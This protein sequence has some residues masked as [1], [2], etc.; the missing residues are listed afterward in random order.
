MGCGVWAM[1][2]VGMLAFHLNVHIQSPYAGC[3]LPGWG[4]PIF[5]AGMPV[6]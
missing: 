3:I 6:P 4:L 2:F 5:G 1:H